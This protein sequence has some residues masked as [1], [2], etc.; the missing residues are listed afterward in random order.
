M[1]RVRT[2]RAI[3]LGLAVTACGSTRPRPDE[4]PARR[5]PVDL[6]AALPASAPLHVAFVP[7]AW[8]AATDAL[9]ARAV[10]FVEAFRR[11]D[12]G[13]T[14]DPDLWPALGIDERAP[15]WFSVDG[16]D[17]SAVSETADD[18]GRV[19]MAPDALPRW[20]AETIAPPAWLHL[21]LA[22]APTPTPPGDATT[23]WLSQRF[24]AIQSVSVDEG[25]DALAV[26]LDSDSEE[27]VDVHAA[28][29]ARGP[30]RV[31]RLLD[32]SPAVVI[33]VTRGADRVLVDW[34]QDR[35]LGP[36]ALA[37]GL[38]AAL[39]PQSPSRRAVW[40]GVPTS[41]EVLRAT[42]DHRGFAR[43][44]RVMADAQV[45]G[46]TLALE[47]VAAEAVAASLAQ[48]RAQAALPE[49]LQ[50]AGQDVFGTSSLRLRSTG[51]GA[52]GGSLLVDIEARYT[53]RGRGLA[54]LSRGV[55]ALPHRL[56]S[57]TTAARFT[58]ATPGAA[59]LARLDAVA[60]RPER[61]LDVHLTDVARC[62]FVC[63]PSLWTSLPTYAR[64]P[65]ESLG[66]VLPEVA[67]LAPALSGAQ[68]ISATWSPTPQPGF[69]LTLR[70]GQGAGASAR[71]LPEG[72]SRRS[73]M[74]V[75]GPAV[76]IANDAPQLAALERAQ[77]L[78]EAG[79]RETPTLLEVSLE[80]P[81]A[82]VF[83]RLDIRLGFEA[84]AMRLSGSFAWLPIAPPAGA[85][86]G[87]KIP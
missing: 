80:G 65:L 39:A 2:A 48:G 21:R 34:V 30:T 8:R 62:G 20:R 50:A 32:A 6:S 36:G 70:P 25:A 58:V 40:A 57:P 53:D 31:Y 76:L 35:M 47:G 64:A 45:L 11:S 44:A 15:A 78:S 59:A 82:S 79:A 68:G 14:L 77:A 4:P 73:V 66:A 55:A 17:A 84:E 18:L 61:G 51:D 86:N 38:R 16:G 37:A 71:P 19:L 28:L 87:H 52:A 23:L 5:A 67:V 54:E 13:F 41:G 43:W 33:V 72:L 26:A 12:A 22:G 74:A 42:L 83:R 75:D 63:W 56:L 24:G 60:P 10:S 85:E 29:A 9:A 69:A 49:R 81:L 46:E 1:R 27:A 3:I 7:S